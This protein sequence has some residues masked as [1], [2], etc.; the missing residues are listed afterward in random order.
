MSLLTICHDAA[1]EIDILR[2]AT[3]V[4]NVSPDARTLLRLA[5]KVGRKIMKV[6]PWQILRKEHTFTAVAGETQTGI[7]PADFDRFVAETFWN[8]SGT[9]L[10]TGPISSVEWQGLKAMD[11]TPEYPKFIYQG[12][13]VKIIPGMG[14]GET[15]AFEYISENWCKASDTTPKSS[16][17]A[18]TD[19]GIIDEEL[20]TRALVLEYLSSKGQPASKALVDYETYFN[21]LVGND[22]PTARILLSADIFGGGRHFGGTPRTELGWRR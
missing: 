4:N 12:D 11:Q 5:N 15:L 6:F 3:I 16:F 22:Q 7:I 9:V 21:D 20:L 19:T 14:G 1:D 17:T 10:I 18:D 8:R 13:V 2:P